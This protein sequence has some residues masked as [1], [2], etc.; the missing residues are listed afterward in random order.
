MTREMPL[1]LDWL[2]PLDRIK[3]QAAVRAKLPQVE[4]GKYT[5]KLRYIESDGLVHFE[6]IVGPDPDDHEPLVPRG[7]LRYKEVLESSWL[8]GE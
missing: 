5:L 8:A 4:V 7:Y 2:N 1:Q 6:P 3:F